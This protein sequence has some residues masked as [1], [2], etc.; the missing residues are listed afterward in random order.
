[1]KNRSE[2]H[3]IVYSLLAAQIE[4][5]TYRFG[6]PLPKME[7][8][9]RWLSVSLD[10][11]RS[12]YLQLKRDGYITLTKK[13]GAAVAVRFQES[14][15]E[16]H[17]QTFFALRKDAVTDLCRSLDP[18]FSH[19]QWFALKYA[20]PERLDELERLCLQPETLPP[21]VMVR[22]VRL[23]YETLNNDLLLRLVWQAFLFYQAPFL[24]LPENMAA[25][26]KGDGPLLEMIGLCRRKD[27]NGLW[28][29]VASYQEQLNRA[30]R[31]FYA[32]HITCEPVGNPIF[33]HWDAYEKSSQRCYSLAL[34]LLNDIY[35]GRYQPEHFL[36]SPS[37]IGEEKQ[38]SVTTVRRTLTLLGH[39][40]ATRSI[41]GVGTQ[42]LS[43]AD[44]SQNCDFS[45]P[46]IQKRLL[47]FAQSLQ[48][49]AL[50]CGA[51]LEITLDTMDAMAIQWWRNRLLALK[52]NGR[53]ES[54]VF[55]SLEVIPHF[56]PIRAVREIYRQLLRILIW[57]YPLRS[58]HGSREQ[59]NA[60]YL[61]YINS[62]LEGLRQGDKKRLTAALE[63]M[64]L[65]EF[66]FAVVRLEELDVQG[67]AG[68][69]VPEPF[70]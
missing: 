47:D 6:D 41:N 50:T 5:G 3:Q 62:L 17:I 18:L 57:G 22:H 39:L 30:I 54:V 13:A 24:S 9:A 12:A 37:K 4:F 1:M 31:R 23:I 10:T 29:T 7:E 53:Y 27:W 66:R 46:V 64:L 44:S 33:F 52:E 58:L 67:A 65:C 28:Q 19:A 68:L 14:E 35:L 61:P 32:D 21:Y 34:D 38:V 45:Q 69:L 40:G 49:M 16:E 11:V 51:C 70:R 43:P 42:A 2:L 26:E 25:F 48:I 59:I 20:G 60:F 36:P 8:T 15:F 55:D 56:S 63:Q